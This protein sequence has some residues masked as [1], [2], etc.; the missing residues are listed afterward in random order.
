MVQARAVLA[1]LRLA[2][3]ADSGNPTMTGHD[4]LYKTFEWVSSYL[5]ACLDPNAPYALSAYLSGRSGE[6]LMALTRM[7]TNE[8]HHPP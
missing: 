4:T 3:D 2:L 5:T 1:L 8:R 6:E 7:I